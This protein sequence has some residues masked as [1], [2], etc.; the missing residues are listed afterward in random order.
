MFKKILRY[1]AVLDKSGEGRSTLYM[2][3]SNGLWTRPVRIG[4]RA[5]GWPDHEVD[6]ILAA[7]IAGK[8]DAE[9]RQLVKQ[10]EADRALIS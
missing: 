6:A 3:I 4:S 1:W 7:R 10:L 2:K 8:S 9:I 5:V